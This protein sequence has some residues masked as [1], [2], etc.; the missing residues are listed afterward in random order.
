MTHYIKTSEG[1]SNDHYK[2][3]P[4]YGKFGEGQGKAS[5]LSN[6]LFQSSTILNALHALVSG[7]F[8]FSICQKFTAKCTAEAYVDDA[9]CTYIDQTKQSKTPAQIR[10]KIQHIAQTWENLLY[11]TGGK[12]SLKKTH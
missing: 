5:S 12:L 3:T 10:Q 8:L 7:I 4:E 2:H 6:W 9:D 1:V 11:D